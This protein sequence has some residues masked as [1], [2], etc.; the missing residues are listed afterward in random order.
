MFGSSLT[1]MVWLI[2]ARRLEDIEPPINT[3]ER[4]SENEG[5][6][7]FLNPFS[8]PEEFSISPFADP[9][10]PALIRGRFWCSPVSLAN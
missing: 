8:R 5:P 1:I 6:T 10:S 2:L 4:G 9:R 3:G 7:G